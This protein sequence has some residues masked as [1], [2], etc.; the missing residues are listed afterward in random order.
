M[1][2]SFNKCGFFNVIEFLAHRITSNIRDLEGALNRITA[3]STLIGRKITLTMV[4]DVL[5]DLLISNERLVTIDRIQ[6]KVAEHYNIKLSDMYSPKRN[7]SLVRPRQ[8]AMYLCKRLTTYSLPDI[9][10]RFGGRD[11]TTVIY[12]IRKVEELCRSD[13]SFAEH[14]STLKRSLGI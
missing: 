8:V 1:G 13:S 5:Q 3:Y 6:K 14:I 2:C 11:H 7:R 4:Q 10:F 9:G 12:A